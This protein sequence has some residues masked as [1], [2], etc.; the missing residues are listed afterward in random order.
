MSK[1]ATAKERAAKI[2]ETAVRVGFTEKVYG[3]ATESSSVRNGDRTCG[4]V[5][6]D[7]CTSSPEWIVHFIHVT[8]LLM[9]SFYCGQERTENLANNS[10]AS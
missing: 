6:Q 8:C 2:H 9:V 10:G 1:Y 3:T 7:I 5:D 4:E